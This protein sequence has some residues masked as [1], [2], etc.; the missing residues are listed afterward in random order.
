M[1]VVRIN[2]GLSEWA[3]SVPTTQ[4]V[5]AHNLSNPAEAI[6]DIHSALREALDHPFGLGF[7]LRRAFTSDDR[8]A[9][10]IDETLPQLPRLIEGV[11]EYLGSVG[12]PPEATTI[13]SP[14]R[15]RF[16]DWIDELADE[17][18]DV[19]TELHDPSDRGAL[20]YL[21][22]TRE[23]RRIYLNRTLLDADQIIVLSRRPYNTDHVYAGAASSIFPGLSD[24]ET[25]LHFHKAARSE[26][27]AHKLRQEAE[28]IG[29]L[30]SSM[31]NIQAIAGAGDSLERVCAGL[32]NASAEGMRLQ[33]ERWCFTVAEEVDLVVAALSGDPRRHDFAMLAAAA[34][35]AASIVKERGFII[36]LSEAEPEIDAGIEAIRHAED[37]EHALRL[38]RSN[39]LPECASAMSWARAA[40]H[41]RLYLASGMK[42]EIVEEIFAT[43]LC[44]PEEVQRLIR[45]AARCLLIP[46]AHK[47]QVLRKQEPESR[48]I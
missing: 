23:G 37:P 8:I 29:E 18:S 15:S 16:N 41:A 36:I 20:S 12:I 4:L 22:T 45:Q 6:I 27:R 21:T 47:S 34:A 1:H 48:Q 11:L 9:L 5:Q 2:V 7:S 26:D 3:I 28:Q 24:R 14:S 10:V 44:T 33:D 30:L 43:P 39:Q 17:L 13:I 38:L 19:K 42:P 25:L 40:N 46:D 31:I 35:T 32:F